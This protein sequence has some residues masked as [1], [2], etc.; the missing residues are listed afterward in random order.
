MFKVRKRNLCVKFVCLFFF[1]TFTIL[2]SNGTNGLAGMFFFSFYVLALHI[3]LRGS[4][5]VL[6]NDVDVE[7]QIRKISTCS[8]SDR[9]KALA[10]FCAQTD[11]K[12]KFNRASKHR[13]RFLVDYKNKI[14]TCEVSLAWSGTCCV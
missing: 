1:C 8:A 2:V 6:V 10:F 9:R 4:S 7:T 5:C 12:E 3:F 11:K 13:S 14:L